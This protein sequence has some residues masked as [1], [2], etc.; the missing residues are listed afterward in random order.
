MEA[1]S[2]SS[3][4]DIA[5]ELKQFCEWLTAL[6]VRWKGTRVAEYVRYFDAFPEI[7]KDAIAGRIKPTDDEYKKHFEMALEVVDFGRIYR[8]FSHRSDDAIRHRLRKVR[9]GLARRTEEDDTNHQAR[10]FS[11]ELTT[12]AEISRNGVEVD[13]SSDADVR[14]P[15][16]AGSVMLI[17]CK[18]PRSPNLITHRV[19]SGLSQ[20]R[21]RAALEHARGNRFRSF[22]ALNISYLVNPNFRGLRFSSASH[23]GNR[24]AA[25]VAAWVSDN[26]R[27]LVPAFRALDCN[28]MGIMLVVDAPGYV[29]DEERE[30]VAHQVNILATRTYSR[31]DRQILEELGLPHPK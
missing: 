14:V 26:H 21:E 17:E 15:L 25:I 18:R 16:A 28:L 9:H 30:Y 19:I 11:F 10:D 7:Q 2:K 4:E 29:L 1:I 8:A 3:Y 13:L 27:S 6:N 24:L 23:I 12:A 31:V 20:L 5:A 22:L